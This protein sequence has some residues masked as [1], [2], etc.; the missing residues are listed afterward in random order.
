VTNY[1][2]LELKFKKKR[3][4]EEQNKKDIIQRKIYTNFSNYLEKKSKVFPTPTFFK[5]EF[6]HYEISRYELKHFFSFVLRNTIDINRNTN[7]QNH[8][9]E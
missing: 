5:N 3:R 4:D 6:D 2:S 1:F 8:Q 9:I 7:Y